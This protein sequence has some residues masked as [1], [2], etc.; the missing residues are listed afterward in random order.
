MKLPRLP[1]IHNDFRGCI[2]GTAPITMLVV[3]G[4]PV[5]D[6]RSFITPF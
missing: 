4:L 1:K 3:R 2:R 6:A 5:P